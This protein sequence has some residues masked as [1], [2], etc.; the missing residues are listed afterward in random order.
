MRMNRCGRKASTRG[1]FRLPWNSLALP[2]TQRKFL[3][4]YRRILGLA[5]TKCRCASALVLCSLFVRLAA[6]QISQGVKSNVARPG[7]HQSSYLLVSMDDT[8]GTLGP[9]FRGHDPEAIIDLL[10]APKRDQVKSEFE[11]SAEFEH[12]QQVAQTR[13]FLGSLGLASTLAFTVQPK[14]ETS[15]T[16]WESHYDAD[17]GILSVSIAFTDH[18]FYFAAGKPRLGTVDLKEKS[19]VKIM[20]L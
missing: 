9:G 1:G 12:R 15:E 4:D 16:G 17:S 20:L 19:R 10:V 6:P 11:T 14:S 2:E 8:V 3:S 13:P 7:S 18:E 5:R